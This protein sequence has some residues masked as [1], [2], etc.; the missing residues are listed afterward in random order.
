MHGDGQI[1]VAVDYT[2]SPDQKKDIILPRFGLRMEVNNALTQLDW[3]GHGPR[4]TY[5]DRN[6]ELIGRYSN[7]VGGLFADYSRPQENGN[8]HG[9]RRAFL[10]NGSGIGLKI[11]ASADAPINVSARRHTSQELNSFKYSYQLPPSNR[12]YLNIDGHVNGVAGI[13]TWGARPLSQYQLNADQPMSYRFI[14]LG[15]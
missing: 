8:L 3:Y 13:N 1:A 10:S 12:V 6:F 11:I 5:I 2:P 15:K 14:L 7:T 9:I 4:E